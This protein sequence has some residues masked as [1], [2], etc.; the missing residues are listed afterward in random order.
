MCQ[1]V[2]CVTIAFKSHLLCIND[3][4]STPN[5]ALERPTERRKQT[6]ITIIMIIFRPSVDMLPKGILKVTDRPRPNT[7]MDTNTQPVKSNAGKLS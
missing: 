1:S 7:K 2:K 5:V 3:V 6:K 4:L